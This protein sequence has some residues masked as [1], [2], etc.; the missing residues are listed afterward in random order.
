ML[1]C[2]VPWFSKPMDEEFDTIKRKRQQSAFE[3]P[4]VEKAQETTTPSTEAVT[5]GETSTASPLGEA[6]SFAS[7][8]DSLNSIVESKSVNTAPSPIK[9]QALVFEEPSM[10]EV[11]EET[12]KVVVEKQKVVE[13]KEV[14]AEKEEK[15]KAAETKQKPATQSSSSKFILLALFVF[16]LSQIGK[17]F[18]KKAVPVIPAEA[19]VE[20]K[21]S[22][23]T[24][25]IKDTTNDVE[26][27]TET[28]AEIYSEDIDN[29]VEIDEAGEAVE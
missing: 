2:P 18:P 22:E 5:P 23:A 14:I 7:S 6:S 16:L 21:I 15:G 12:E 24:I 13:E 25:D 26:I 20:S 27:D 4:L 10:E 11:V 8:S 3:T 29:N 9:P 17:F 28:G 19:I 1:F